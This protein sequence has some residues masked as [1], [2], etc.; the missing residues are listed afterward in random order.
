MGAAWSC[1]VQ[2][3]CYPS[4]A[5]GS[6]VGPTGSWGDPSLP[7]QKSGELKRWGLGGRKFLCFS[8]P[9]KPLYFPHH[10]C[11]SPKDRNHQFPQ[12][13]TSVFVDGDSTVQAP[14]FEHSRAQNLHF[15][16]TSLLR[17]STGNIVNNIIRIMYSARWVLDLWGHHFVSYVN[18]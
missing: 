16:K 3:H 5:A 9:P 7:P 18:V 13:P 12:L 4:A 17:C 1:P 8:R 11:P 15:N 14:K 2:P 6:G 10:L